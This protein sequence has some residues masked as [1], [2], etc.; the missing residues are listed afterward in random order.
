[1]KILF[2]VN[3]KPRLRHFEEVIRALSDRG[4]QVRLALPDVAGVLDVFTDCPNV[5][6]VTCPKGRRDRW[7]RFVRYVRGLRDYVRYGE[8][9]FRGATALRRRAYRRV[10]WAPYTWLARLFLSRWTRRPMEAV[11]RTIEAAIP[12][13]AM[14]E[15]FVESERPD[16]VLVT[17]LVHFTSSYQVDFVKA[18]HRLGLPVAFLPYSWDNLTNKGHMRVLPDRVF[19]WNETQKTEA[20]ELHDVPPEK[21]VVCGGWRFDNFYALEPRMS[22]EEF[23]QAVGLRPDRPYLVYLCS[24]DFVA[25]AE[26]EFVQ[27]LVRRI[28]SS[29]DPVLA[30]CGILIK[31]Y[32][33]DYKKWKKLKFVR[34]YAD[35][36]VLRNDVFGSEETKK[37]RWGA[38]LLYETLHHAHAV[39]GLNTSAMIEAAIL[40]KP[41]FSLLVK[42]F[43]E[44]QSGTVHFHYFRTVGGG[45]I[46]LAS[47]VGDL[48]RR[49]SECLSRPPVRDEKSLAFVRAFVRPEGLDRPVVPVV[50]GEIERLREIEKRSPA[51]APSPSRAE[52]RLF[53]GLEALAFARLMETAP[54]RALVAWVVRAG[55]PPSADGVAPPDV[56]KSPAREPANVE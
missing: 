32:P 19:V 25:A 34:K 41:V 56:P 13:D 48:R 39:F 30:G 38:P 8:P 17:P 53:S 3:K 18:A 22:K 45:L 44:G 43:E 28:K 16:V 36:V 21:V 1:M 47:D 7:K 6:S 33:Q 2:F 52:D 50:V 40:A 46:H 42:Q 55:T 23:C 35:V 29:G 24:S 12:S 31:P 54:A 14:T 27:S 10:H 11:L 51:S 4:H 20:V 9:R 37:N 26:I 49:L 15:K 5:S